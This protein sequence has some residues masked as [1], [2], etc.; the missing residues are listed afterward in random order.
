MNSYYQVFHSPHR[1]GGTGVYR[2]LF[3]YIV[4]VNGDSL[5]ILTINTFWTF[6]VELKL[7][8]DKYLWALLFSPQSCCS[9]D[10][11]FT[12]ITFPELSYLVL[13]NMWN[14]FELSSHSPQRYAVRLLTNSDWTCA[15]LAVTSPGY[16][17]R[18]ISIF[19]GHTANWA[20]NRTVVGLRAT[21][22]WLL[23]LGLNK[24]LNPQLCWDVTVSVLKV[25]L[26]KKCLQNA[27]EVCLVPLM[28]KN[29]LLRNKSYHLIH[30]CLQTNF[31]MHST[32]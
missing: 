21:P 31:E 24:S 8:L 19:N 16:L 4:S 6:W 18:Q 15:C 23:L 25:S 14:L 13:T 29:K 5:L 9:L 10:Y 30:L 26:G 27:G 3:K 28:N 1:N 20:C 12:V 22:A 11:L 7:S 2:L 17:C 32:I